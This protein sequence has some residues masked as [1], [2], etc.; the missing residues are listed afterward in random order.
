VRVTVR[1]PSPLRQFAESRSKV[2]LDVQDDG[3]PTVAAVL[4]S[5]R[6]VYPGVY[7]RTLDER[8]QIRQHMNI[9][10]NSE[11]VKVTSGL[12]TPVSP[13]DEISII[14]AVSGG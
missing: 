3:V 4:T 6:E 12:H 11:N 2:F 8:G 5:L 13:G 14:P 9:F 1:V 10:L 7:E